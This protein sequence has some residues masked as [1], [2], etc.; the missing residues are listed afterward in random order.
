MLLSG[1]LNWQPSLVQLS[2]IG[3]RT[4]TD[5]CK[6]GTFIWVRA[7][8]DKN[9]HIL[10]KATCKW[11]NVRC[12]VLP[13]SE[14]IFFQLFDFTWYADLVIQLTY[15][16]KY[17]YFC[18]E[19]AYNVFILQV[20]RLFLTCWFLML[21]CDETLVLNLGWPSKLGRWRFCSENCRGHPY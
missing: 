21:F 6:S 8:D 4:L 5:Q 11:N 9:L 18:I 16:I 1:S 17:P 20:G 2:F 3:L 13:L 19:V 14:R 12:H 7:L 10:L 15:E